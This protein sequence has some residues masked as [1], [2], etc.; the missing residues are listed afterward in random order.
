MPS[1]ALVG[2]DAEAAQELP[3]NP[4]LAVVYEREYNKRNV[5]QIESMRK[6][7]GCHELGG[8]WRAAPHKFPRLGCVGCS[9]EPIMGRGR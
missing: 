9:D 4:A 6:C 1:G 3:V 7:G 2:E 8:G 5:H